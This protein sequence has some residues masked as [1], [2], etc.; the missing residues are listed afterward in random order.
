MRKVG[1]LFAVVLISSMAMASD[2]AKPDAPKTGAANPPTPI[3]AT[4]KTA[5]TTKASA[6]WTKENLT[7]MTMD[8]L[9]K[10]GD[11][12]FTMRNAGRPNFVEHDPLGRPFVDHG[13]AVAGISQGMLFAGE[14]F[15]SYELK[16]HS[17]PGMARAVMLLGIGGNT[18]GI[19]TSTR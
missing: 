15:V 5:A 13:R 11:M 7:L 2:E 14:V 16:R 8:A 1:A 17:H 3:V 9:A 10:S 4:S 12:W 6:I 18:A 19:A